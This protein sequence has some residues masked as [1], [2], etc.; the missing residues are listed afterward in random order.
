MSSPV[1]LSHDALNRLDRYVDG[2][3]TDSERAQF[4]RELEASPELRKHLAAQS[5]LDNE[6]GSM[7]AFEQRQI[8]FSAATPDADRDALAP[9][10]IPRTSVDAWARTSP[11]ARLKWI[12]LAAAVLLIGA[13]V[14]STYVHLTTPTFDRIIQPGELYAEMKA[15]GFPVEFV[16]T[17][18]AEFAK[19]ISDRFGQGLVLAQTPGL[20]ALGWAYGDNYNGTILGPKTLVLIT[21]VEPPA[22]AKAERVLVLMDNNGNDRTLNV[23]PDSGLRL[24]RRET[25]RLVLY[26]ITPLDKSV[27]L[28]RLEKRR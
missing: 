24:F 7:F 11:F 2:L 3:M 1:P 23:P 28:D 9:I 19:A 14:W 5:R 12:G 21:S 8:D 13:G 18:D 27:V 15:R 26:E 17:T 20:S 25:E 4:E 6:L 10:P 22:A 16:C